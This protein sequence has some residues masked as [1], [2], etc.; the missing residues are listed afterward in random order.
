MTMLQEILSGVQQ[1]E[2]DRASHQ[3]SATKAASSEERRD[4]QRF[5]PGES[6]LDDLRPG[7]AIDQAQEFL[8]SNAV[9]MRVNDF[10][11]SMSVMWKKRVK[12]TGLGLFSVFL[13]RCTRRSS[14]GISFH[15][16]A[17]LVPL[18]WLCTT[19]LR[20]DVRFARDPWRNVMLAPELAT[21]AVV[22]SNSVQFNLAFLGECDS[23]RRMIADRKASPRDR[24]ENGSTMLHVSH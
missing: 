22:P 2:A 14:R 16:R 10:Y 17:E 3:D 8:A 12:I 21:F 15:A 1:T 11:G 23:L 20:V 5:Q 4:V 6:A 9:T 19:G 24:D 7:S 18:P 13:F